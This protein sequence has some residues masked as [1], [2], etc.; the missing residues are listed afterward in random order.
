MDSYNKNVSMIKLSLYLKENNTEIKKFHSWKRPN[1]FVWHQ[2]EQ[3]FLRSA[4]WN[5]DCI[6]A[7]LYSKNSCNVEI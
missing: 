7:S 1:V 5:T 2:I 3:S 6:K 4:W